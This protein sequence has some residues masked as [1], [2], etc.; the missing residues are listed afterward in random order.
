ML[1]IA[2]APRPNLLQRAN[3]YGFDFH[4]I[5]GEPYWDENHYYQFTLQQIERDLEDPTNELEALCMDLVEQVVRDEYW[6]TKLQIPKHQWQLILD[7]WRFKE[8]SLYGRMDFAY[9]G[10]GPA[11]LL[12]YNAD[13]PTSIYEA[14]FFQWI[15]L[16]DQVKAGTL[17][18]STDQFNSIQEKLI[19]QMAKIPSDG[20]MHFACCQ[21]STEDRA[22]V[23]YLEDCAQQAGVATRFIYVEDI[24]VNTKGQFTDLDDYEISCL[25]KLYPWEWMLTD[26]FSDYL[27]KSK[28]RFVEPAWKAI[29]SNKGILP[30]LWQF[31]KGHPN[32]LPS[33]FEGEQKADLG[34][35]Y[36]KK[37]LF[38]REG[39]NISLIEDGKPTLAV[40]GEYGEEGYI[41]Q[42]LS[43][44]PR[45]NESF[46][47][48]GSWVVGHEAAGLTIREDN[49]LITK[50][51]SRFVPHVIVG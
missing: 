12:E 15:W 36:C 45:F 28:T 49:S 8:P 13:T 32:L 20:E 30:L 5:D 44:L 47:L 22:T 1:R 2:C 43:P 17:L 14:A 21:D 10:N 33:Y 7:S 16:E 41:Y 35:S 25:F 51:T 19:A 29:L 31:H 18:R 48:I 11:K 9:N 27:A 38:S 3:Q 23:E 50:D 37:P 46:T 40:G 42:S 26:P 34:N 39:A 6:L 4:T 24:G